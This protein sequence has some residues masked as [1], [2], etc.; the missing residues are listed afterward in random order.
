MNKQVLFFLLIALVSFSLCDDVS[1]EDC[2]SPTECYINSIDQFNI[3][4]REMRVGIN[5]AKDQIDLYKEEVITELHGIMNDRLRSLEEQLSELDEVKQRISK[6]ENKFKHWNSIY[7]FLVG[8]YKYQGS[9]EAYSFED[10][11][12]PEGSEEVLVRVLIDL[13]TLSPQKFFNTEVYLYTEENKKISYSLEAEK[14][15][16]SAKSFDNSLLWF[17]LNRKDKK[18]YIFSDEIGS[19]SHPDR[20][21]CRVSIIGF[22]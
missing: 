19:S 5:K 3:A 6:V 17:P 11:N 7:P 15:N 18:I 8:T 21:V 20:A 4:K 9:E 14:Y 13:G 10:L 22:R 1:S 16:Q 2:S 12:I